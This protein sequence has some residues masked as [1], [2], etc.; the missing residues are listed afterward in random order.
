M[1]HIGDAVEAKNHHSPFAGHL[2]FFD[3]A[4]DGNAVADGEGGDIERVIDGGAVRAF[5]STPAE[6]V[7]V[8]GERWADRPDDIV[9]GPADSGHFRAAIGEEFVFHA[10]EI[11]Q[12]PAVTA[13]VIADF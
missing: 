11:F 12:A 3:E 2:G 13:G 7:A 5:V 9:N 10:E 1:F 4:F 6:G 8:G